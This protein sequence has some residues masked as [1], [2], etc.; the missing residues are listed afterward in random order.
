MRELE[1]HLP[2]EEY[3][4]LPSRADLIALERRRSVMNGS[5]A[6]KP[7]G[8]PLS[9]GRPLSPLPR[10][11]I[12][13]VAASMAAGMGAA[14]GNASSRKE[15]ARSLGN[16]VRKGFEKAKTAAGAAASVAGGVG[17]S[18][19]GGA[20]AA[21]ACGDAAATDRGD[22]K[23][24]SGGSG[25]GSGGIGAA[26]RS[27][28]SGIRVS[29]KGKEASESLAGLMLLQELKS[30]NGPIWTAAFNHSGKFLATTGQDMKILLHH[31][32]DVTQDP[33]ADYTSGG[34]GNSNSGEGGG[35]GRA[36]EDK[37][38]AAD[39][40]Q[41][42]SGKSSSPKGTDSETNG[43]RAGASAPR[44]PVHPG[45]GGG[46]DEKSTTTGAPIG[47][48][49]GGR[50]ATEGGTSDAKEGIS[51]DKR[52]SS[53]RSSGVPLFMGLEPCQVW[54]AHRADVVALSWSR[55]DFLLSASLDKTV[56]SVS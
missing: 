32:G 44:P 33:Y 37:P 54:E 20:T 43:L 55:N 18:S 36:S 5:G 14:V 39:G 16:K 15:R 34:S 53:R 56:S 29:L 8:R 4:L 13:S 11:S 10:P 35:G 51:G 31:V 48:G 22:K 49:R 26:A 52:E 2:P 24:T 23:A 41:G 9:L 17:G 7:P 47:A 19:G 27:A 3:N 25:G 40:N 12:S 30:H 46:R 6:P 28:L 42:R 1:Q 50:E 45:N 38:G 21:A